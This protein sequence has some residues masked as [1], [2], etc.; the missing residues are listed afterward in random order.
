MVSSTEACMKTLRCENQAA[1]CA[2]A[3]LSATFRG[4]VCRP[5]LGQ[6]VFVAIRA[7]VASCIIVRF[8]S[9][10]LSPAL[11]SPSPAPS[12]TEGQPSI[13]YAIPSLR[14]YAHQTANETINPAFRMRNRTAKGN[15]VITRARA[16]PTE[17]GLVGTTLPACHITSP[18][19]TC[20]RQA[21]RRSKALGC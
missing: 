1:N 17:K 18:S 10:P 16:K 20:T 9:P 5:M 19:Q 13:L 21:T 12:E 3:A 6:L 7:P 15:F 4:Q 11:S 14:T 8:P 2:M